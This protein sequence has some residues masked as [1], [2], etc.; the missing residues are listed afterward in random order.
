MQGTSDHLA[1]GWKEYITGTKKELQDF[2]KETHEELKD[3]WKHIEENTRGIS[4]L[5]VK[6]GLI[7]AFVGSIP[8]LATAIILFLKVAK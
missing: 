1:N 8:A 5:H 4:M 2:K 7:Y 6:S 3:L